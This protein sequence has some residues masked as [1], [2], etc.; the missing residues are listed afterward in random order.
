MK[1]K[2]FYQQLLS[3]FSVILITVLVLSLSL[4]HY[5][6]TVVYEQKTDELKTYG[7]AILTDLRQSTRGSN[8]ILKTYGHVLD[9][10]AIQYSL[11]DEHSSIVY[12]TGL[13]SP[14]IELNQEEWHALQN[15]QTVTVKQEFKRFDEAVTFV[16]L[17]YFERQQFDGGVLLTSPITGS[18]AIISQMNHYV[19]YATGAA[20]LLA[21]L[22]SGL[23]SMIH[24]R[25]IQRLRRAAATVAGGDYTVRV[26]S[27]EFDEIGELSKDF[28]EMTDKLETSMKEIDT[29]EKR[30]RQFM[31]DVSHELRTPLTTIRGVIEGL[32]ERMI[33]E[34]EQDKALQLAQNE[35]KRLIRL[36][37]E[38]LDYEKIRANQIQLNRQRLPLKELFE[39]TADQLEHAAAERGNTI[40]VNASDQLS[41]FADYDRLMQIF[42]NITK[43]SI[44][45]CEN[46]TITLNAKENEKETIIE[47]EDTGI[48][49]NPAE[50]EQIWDRFY[51]AIISR[52]STPYGEFG[53]GL[54]IVKQLVLLHEGRIDV[55]SEKGK[56]ALFTIRLPKVDTTAVLE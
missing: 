30:R 53:L 5:L 47:I 45:F 29:L 37:N 24:V 52:T 22:L 51:K 4:T 11:F 44:Q 23:L 20:V 12:S 46:G 1:I 7:Q 25:R 27:S 54:S 41:V 26:P 32:R 31:A 38:N 39:M 17:P 49:M 13:K 28:N 50:I 43:N 19:L 15:G 14:L 21:L 35:S 42:I 18:R 3:H 33:S 48:G 10:R 56:G 6:E 36:V 2:T 55:Q 9:T 40:I 16:L 34:D 8:G